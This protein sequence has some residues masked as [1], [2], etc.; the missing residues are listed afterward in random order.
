M[1]FI[2]SGLR[3]ELVCVCLILCV[4]YEHQQKIT[5]SFN[6][7]AAES[8]INFTYRHSNSN[9][10]LLAAPR[11]FGCVSRVDPFI[12]YISKS[13]VGVESNRILAGIPDRRESRAAWHYAS[14]LRPL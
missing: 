7:A 4:I 11:Q 5:P 9:R 14:S 1:L 3:D 10:R 6:L 12:G 2:G 8:N 13:A